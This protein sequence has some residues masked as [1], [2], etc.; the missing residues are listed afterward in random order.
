MDNN[1]SFR[2]LLKEFIAFEKKL[3]D[4]HGNISDIN[5]WRCKTLIY[6]YNKNREKYNK[7]KNKTME[8]LNEILDNEMLRDIND[9]S[10]LLMVEQIKNFKETCYHLE[11]YIDGG[12]M[13][14]ICI[15]KGKDGIHKFY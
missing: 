1:Y 4:S 15:D 13:D 2:N 12:N 9:N 3:I 7:Y 11:E 10:I 8:G 14:H 5:K 6:G